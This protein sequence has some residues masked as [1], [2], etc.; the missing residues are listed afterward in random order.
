MVLVHTTYVEAQ[1]NCPNY[2]Y[3]RPFNVHPGWSWRPNR[4]IIVSIDDGWTEP[5]RNA[6]ADG[7]EK[8]NTWNGGNCSGV[9]FAGFFEKTYTGPEYTSD[10]PDDNLYWQRIDPQ[11]GSAAG[12]KLTL[13]TS[14]R[15][16]S[17]RIQ[18]HPTEQNGIQG[19]YYI[20]LGAHEVGHT[21]NLENCL[22]ANQCV[23]SPEKSVMSG[24]GSVSFNSN[25]PLACDQ[26]AV[27]FEYCP[28]IAP[29]TPEDCTNQGMYW[30][31][32]QGS[33]NSQFQSCPQFCV[34][35]GGIDKNSC[36]Y[37]NGCPTGWYAPTQSS[38][39]CFPGS[40]I[41]IDVNG[42]GFSLT[43]ATN[44][45]SFDISGNGFSQR[46]AW[47]SVISDDAWLVLDRNNNGIIDNGTELFGN[48]TPQSVP[49]A[50]TNR[51]GFLAL[52]EYDKPANGGDND[53]IIT[54]I[55]SVFSSLRLWQD[56]NHNGV[57]EASELK[58]LSELGLAT[59]ELDYKMSKKTD[60]F[61][62]A[63]RYRAKVK[64]SQKSQVGRWAWDVFLVSGP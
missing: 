6:I 60:E 40:P 64:D 11:N 25:V 1:Y 21:F 10:P 37:A 24:Q 44:G 59:I 43:S 47:T 29:N 63:F 30:N 13:D 46:M 9:E 15:V 35:E 45:V 8:W 56:V 48:F 41:V 52:A 27:D 18:V 50:G 20:Y 26:G 4:T 2:K 28:Y 57:S 12:T 22:C 54:S 34:Q 31:F 5:D 7:N 49:P 33:C 39:C 23:C 55:D 16:K 17:A 51:N 32:V 61:G 38:P 36:Q 62:N 3:L 58:T 42:D 19:T 53:R 14:Q